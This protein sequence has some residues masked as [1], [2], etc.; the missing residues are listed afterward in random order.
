MLAVSFLCSFPLLLYNLVWGPVEPGLSFDSSGVT[1]NKVQPDTP[2][3]RAGLQAGDR[4]VAIDGMP[5]RPEKG[6]FDYIIAT[7]NLES[8]RPIVMKVESG[9]QRP[10]YPTGDDCGGRISTRYA[11]VGLGSNNSGVIHLHP[12]GDHWYSSPWGYLG[13]N[14]CMDAEHHGNR[15]DL[16]GLWLDF[17]LEASADSLRAFVVDR[18]N[19]P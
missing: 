3:A 9:T 7:N 5:L 11:L 18:L 1:I 6:L 16:Y 8:G 10:T 2:G 19:K 13:T 14:R 15:Y 12:G 4:L 17:L